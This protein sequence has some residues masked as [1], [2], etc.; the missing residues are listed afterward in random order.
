MPRFAILS[1][2]HGNLEALQEVLALCRQLNIDQYISLGDIVGYNAK[3]AALDLNFYKV[4][5]SVRAATISLQGIGKPEVV[6]ADSLSG[7]VWL[8]SEDL[9]SKEEIESSKLSY[10]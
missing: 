4:P 1:D 5:E 7:C 8:I 6:L 3:E 2:I 9:Q 10:R